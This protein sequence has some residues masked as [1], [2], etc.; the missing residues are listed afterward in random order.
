M[1]GLFKSQTQHDEQARDIYALI[2]EQSR[3]PEFYLH[4]G[5]PDTPDGRFDLILVHAFLVFHR[6]KNET[7]EM[8]YL[9]QT[10]FD[11]MFAEWL[12]RIR[13]RPVKFS[14]VFEG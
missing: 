6:L 4:G 13:S 11:L 10:V 9:G 5:V 2:V 1:F 3:R 8:N 12:P 7:S 14:T